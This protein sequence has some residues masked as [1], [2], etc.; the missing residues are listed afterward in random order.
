MTFGLRSDREMPIVVTEEH[1]NVPLIN[2]V[3]ALIIVGMA[4]WLINRFIPMASSIKTT[5]N[6]VV[7][8]FRSDL[9]VAC[10]RTM[11]ANIKLPASAL[12]RFL[13]IGGSRLRR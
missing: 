2:I 8:G 3:I 4:L 11:G 10:N 12:T 6:V 5:L 7:R 9:G 1:K 13:A